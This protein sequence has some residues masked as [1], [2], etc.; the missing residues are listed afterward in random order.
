LGQ[1]TPIFAIGWGY[2][3]FN[4]VFEAS[5]YGGVITI[6]LGAVLISLERPQ[7]GSGFLFCLNNALK[8][9]AAAC[10]IRS[11]SDLLLKYPL[12]EINAWDGFFWQR[13][14]IFIGAL[15]IPAYGS[16]RRQLW[17]ALR[18]MNGRINLLIGG[19]EA[20]ALVGVLAITV[21]YQHGP[22]GLVSASGAT[23]PLFILLLVWYLNRLRPGLVPARIDRRP[24]I[25]RFIPLLL[26]I[27]GVYLL[28][29]G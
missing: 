29:R 16:T 18:Q 15:T 25:N 27:V 17:S 23:Q 11:L 13:L 2:F 19:S 9:M 28:G 10:L 21:A 3:F 8:F 5:N 6:I 26:I 20:I 22:L 12:Q 14:G 4:E 7:K 24:L 1:I